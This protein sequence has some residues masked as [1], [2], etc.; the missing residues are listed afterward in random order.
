M[1]IS[2]GCGMPHDKHNNPALITID[3]LD[4]AANAAGMSTEDAARNI[5]SA[6]GLGCK[7]EEEPRRA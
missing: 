5:A 6:V 4:A 2:C 7:K 3:D 1:C